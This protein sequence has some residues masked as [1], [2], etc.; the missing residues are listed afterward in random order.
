VDGVR[1][2]VVSWTAET[3]GEYCCFV[4]L[5]LARAT[6]GAVSSASPVTAAAIRF[7]IGVEKPFSSRY[8]A[9]DFRRARTTTTPLSQVY[10][11][12]LGRV[13]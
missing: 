4:E 7:M 9:R 6:V 11:S 3:L 2:A 8:G 12:M 5:P 13:S 10:T 1:D